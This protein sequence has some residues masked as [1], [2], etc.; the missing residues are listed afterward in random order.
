[1]LRAKLSDLDFES[2]NIT[3]REKKRDH[4]SATTRRVPMSP[5]LRRAIAAWLRKYP[6]GPFLFCDRL[7]ENGTLMTAI[8]RDV[9]HDHYKLMLAAS[10]WSMMRG[11][12][13]LRHSIASKSAAK[14]IDQ[15][16]INAWLG[17]AGHGS[18]IER[19]Y[20]HLIPIQE[21]LA[22]ASVFG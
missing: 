11:W 3:I 2:G 16:V 19:R 17:H 14:G 6:G 22:I 15:R 21:Q 13:C 4:S 9:V 10:K 18:E 12:H 8:T 7:M 20:R 1:M 5:G